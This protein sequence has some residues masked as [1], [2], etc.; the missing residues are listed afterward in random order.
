MKW[1]ILCYHTVDAE[2]AEAFARQLHW[3]RDQQ[4]YEFRPFGQAFAE[5]TQGRHGKRMTVSFDD[6]DWTVSAVAQKVLDDEGIRAILYLTTDYVLQGTTYRARIVRRAI[7]WEQLG[8]WLESGHELGSH[9][10]THVNLT[11]CESRQL[12]DELGR[13]RQV[14]QERLG[15]TPRHFAYPW[16]QSNNETQRWFRGQ[17][18]W[19]SAALAHGRANGV[20][21]DPYLLRRICMTAD[22]DL[23]AMRRVVRCRIARW[24]FRVCGRLGFRERRGRRGRE[25]VAE[26]EL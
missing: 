13:T 8:R 7:N 24:F 25:A 2:Q 26:T 16:G 22:W 4:G 19:L 11:Q 21:T 6:G 10:H 18:D 5:R 15:I 23:D 20:G 17:T 3:F 1:T 12:L 14:I 9:T